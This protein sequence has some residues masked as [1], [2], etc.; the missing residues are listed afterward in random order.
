MSFEPIFTTTKIITNALT[1]IERARGFLDAVQ[2]SDVWVRTMQHDALVQEA[3]SIT[4]IEGTQLTLE[5][6]ERLLAGETVPEAREDDK[7]ELL[8]YCDA[9]E[10]VAGYVGEGE[11]IT[12]GVVREIHKRLVQG[13]MGNT[14]APGEYRKVPNYVVNSTTKEVIYTPPP[15]SEVPHLMFELV[16]WINSSY[17]LNPILL[18]GLA[19]FQLVHIHPF[20]DGNGRSARLLSTLCLYRFG[21]D[22]KRLFTISEYYDRDR[23]RYYKAIQSVRDNNMEMTGWLEYF[24]TGLAAQ[25]N[26][27]VAKGEIAIKQDLVLSALKEKKE[28]KERQLSLL[29]YLLKKEKATVA[30]CEVVLSINRRT[31]QRDLKLLIGEG[32]VCEI[33][34]SPTDPSKYYEP[35]YDKL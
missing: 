33:A 8:N 12:E 32:L 23:T 17:D 5:Q 11:P 19:Q 21:Y 14:A 34:S 18:S 27:V 20:L 9:F 4:H 29:Q 26:E 6:S 2:L 3:H 7:R 16:R 22:F 31:L 30:E 25:M 13:V 1:K 35:N 24:V 15:A 28:L 10:L